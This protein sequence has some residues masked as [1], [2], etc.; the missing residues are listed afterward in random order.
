[1][2]KLKFSLLFF[3]LLALLFWARGALADTGPKPTMEFTFHQEE[4]AQ[5]LTIASGTLYECHQADCKDAA[6][7]QEGG[8]QRFTCEAATC[9]ALAYGFT[10]YHKLHIQF[11]DN[12]TRESNIFATADFDAKYTVTIR[13]EDLVVEAENSAFPLLTTILFTSLCLLVIGGLVIG[14]LIFLLRRRPKT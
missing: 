1:M 8:P 4:G 13:A 6:P 12:K 9:H 7:L 2:T 11:S 5:P 3:F 14:L 10:P